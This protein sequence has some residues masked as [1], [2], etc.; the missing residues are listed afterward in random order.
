MLGTR[1]HN[2]GLTL[3]IAIVVSCSLGLLSAAPA[4]GAMKVTLSGNQETPQVAFA[5]AE[6][7]KAAESV[8][9]APGP[10]AV[11]F[12]IES[13]SLKA[14]CY[15]IDRVE[16][17]KIRVTGG[18]NGAMY[19][20][21][22]VAEAVRLG[23]LAEMRAG[24]HMPHIEFRGIKFNIPLDART[25]SYSDCRRRARSRISPRCGAWTSG[26]SSLTRWRGTG[27]TC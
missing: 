4:S 11:E 7:R 15:R 18:A 8:K 24:E 19:G 3:S 20:G 1:N 25:P 26:G 27:S 9:D 17:G 21:L 16:G 13:A 5:C 10:L 14:Q 12:A 22:D 6:I 2:P 23:T